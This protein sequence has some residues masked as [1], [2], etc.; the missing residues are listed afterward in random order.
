MRYVALVDA[1]GEQD[2]GQGADREHWHVLAA[3]RRPCTGNSRG[4]QPK[5]SMHTQ[6]RIVQI[7]RNAWQS[8]AKPP[9]SSRKDGRG[10][11]N[12]Q[13]GN[14]DPLRNYDRPSPPTKII[15]TRSTLE[16]IRLLWFVPPRAVPP[17]LRS[18]GATRE[19][20]E[21]R[22]GRK[23]WGGRNGRRTPAIGMKRVKIPWSIAVENL[24]PRF[25][26]KEQPAGARRVESFIEPEGPLRLVE[27]WN[28]HA[29][30]FSSRGERM[31]P[32]LPSGSAGVRG[33]AIYAF[34]TF[35]SPIECAP[36]CKRMVEKGGA[37][38]P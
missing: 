38:R 19:E 25:L 8:R 14:F 23:S 26:G 27:N 18:S 24:S 2:A 5:T 7:G 30:N 9:I 12:S 3:V 16:E 36:M 13:S 11:V 32:L 10:G 34:P 35:H 20:M 15:A 33:S 28:R 6:I 1:T 21:Q 4:L 22:G 37:I 31:H 17:C 29:P